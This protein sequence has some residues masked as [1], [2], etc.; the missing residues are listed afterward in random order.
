MEQ[1]YGGKICAAIDRQHPRDLFDIKY[2]LESEG[3]T[4]KLK[5]GFIYCLLGSERPIY[6]MLNPNR[7]DQQE[8][9]LNQFDGMTSEPFTTCLANS[10]Y[11]YQAST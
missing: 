7:L 3:F 10:C 8:V 9:L 4:D 11:I 6:E 5:A 2:L 1:L